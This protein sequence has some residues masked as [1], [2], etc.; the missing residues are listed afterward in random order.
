M[1]YKTKEEDT[2]MTPGWAT[3]ATNYNTILILY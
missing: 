3:H 1:L 2:K